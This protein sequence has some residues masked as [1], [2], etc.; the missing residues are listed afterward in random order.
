MEGHIVGRPVMTFLNALSMRKKLLLTPALAASLMV[1][2]AM[3]AMIGMRQQ[4]LSLQSISQE[5][6]P[7]MRTAALAERNLASVQASTYKLL[8][9]MDAN[10]PAERVDA[11]KRSISSEL[12]SLQSSLDAVANSSHAD[13]QERTR[14]QAAAK[15]IAEYRKIIDDV[16]DVASVQVSMGTAYMSKAQTKYEELTVQFK[17][18]RQHFVTDFVRPAV[19]PGLLSPASAVVLLVLFF[20]VEQEFTGRLDVS[21]AVSIEYSTVHPC[22]KLPKV[23]DVGALF[24]WVMETI[25]R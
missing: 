24:V 19:A 15:S 12:D 7:A 10:F 8:A 21:P 23:E 13:P 14:F 22:M 1:I 18:A 6:I 16:M 17:Q 2:S 20:I 9:M 11:A 25:V 3:A 5:R 4:W